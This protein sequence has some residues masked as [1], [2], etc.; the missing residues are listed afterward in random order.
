M[1]A[2]DKTGP[3][4]QGP[5]TGRGAGYCAGFQVPGFMNSGPGMGRGRGRGWG[6]GRGGGMGRG[7]GWR[8]GNMITPEQWSDQ[9]RPVHPV[10]NPSQTETVNTSSAIAELK[11]QADQF[12]VT[13]SDIRDQITKLSKE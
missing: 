7:R 13:L 5:M 2:G 1:P 3:M 12:E 6:M 9:F 11:R 4:G 10:A 8:G